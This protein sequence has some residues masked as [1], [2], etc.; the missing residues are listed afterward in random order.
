[1]KKDLSVKE[2]L[3]LY[4][5]QY[6]SDEDVVTK[7]FDIFVEENKEYIGWALEKKAK[8]RWGY[9]QVSFLFLQKAV[10]DELRNKKDKIK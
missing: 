5:R 7:I 6:I 10:L 4:I 9:C 2:A 3:K 8:D 1:M